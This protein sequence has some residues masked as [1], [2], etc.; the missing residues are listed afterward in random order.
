MKCP[1]CGAPNLQETQGVTYGGKKAYYCIVC[2]FKKW[3]YK[4]NN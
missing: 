3:I 2:G 4:Q 1:N